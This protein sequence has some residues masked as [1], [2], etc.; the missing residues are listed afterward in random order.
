LA[1]GTAENAAVIDDVAAAAKADEEKEYE[2]VD[3]GT[4]DEGLVTA[5][6]DVAALVVVVGPAVD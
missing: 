1:Q 2:D 3:L 5:D 4:A 6:E